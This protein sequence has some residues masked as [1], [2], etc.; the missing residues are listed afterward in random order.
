MSTL[1]RKV[2]KYLVSSVCSSII[3]TLQLTSN[4]QHTTF[5]NAFWYLVYF[6]SYIFVQIHILYLHFRVH[7]QKHTIAR[8]LIE[9]ILKLQ[10]MGQGDPEVV[11]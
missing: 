4:Q 5:S 8:P 11:L 6:L 3:S 7:L 2:S 10:G 1:S 9:M